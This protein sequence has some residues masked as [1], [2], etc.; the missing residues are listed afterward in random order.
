[1][2]KQKT[3]KCD[4][5]MSV[6]RTQ[7]MPVWQRHECSTYTK[8]A[9]VTQTWVFNIHKRCQC[10]RGMSVQRTQKMPVWQWHQRCPDTRDIVN[11]AK[12][13][14]QA[15][16][17][18]CNSL[19]SV[20]RDVSTQF[21][22]ITATTRCLRKK[23]DTHLTFNIVKISCRSQSSIFLQCS[24]TVSWATGCTSGL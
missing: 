1:M 18:R 21:H 7:K 4:R 8:D 22:T 19:R 20:N 24:D 12:T 16:T 10:D 13:L 23:H 17:M 15:V 11:S 2:H 14:H 9:S 6:W 3:C 5:G